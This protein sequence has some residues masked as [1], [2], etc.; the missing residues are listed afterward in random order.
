[1][2]ILVKINELK[3]EYES[4]KR[5][6]LLNYEKQREELIKTYS[7]EVA[8]EKERELLNYSKNDITDYFNNF[9]AQA[10]EEV[11]K[12]ERQLKLLEEENKKVERDPVLLNNKLLKLSLIKENS[13]AL[14]KEIE[15]NKEDK[16]ILE[17]I[18]DIS[19]NLDSKE[20]IKNLLNNIKAESPQ[21]KLEQAKRNV[22]YEK[23][24]GAGL[25]IFNIND[26]SAYELN[27]N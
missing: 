19:F 10:N 16:E 24:Q 22:V 6:V 9:I 27:S 14:I 26:T 18:E 7:K 20:D 21:N 5:K 3:K 17:L 1:M 13:K 2:S 8:E 12:E 23:I 25:D 15:N 11:E 4:N